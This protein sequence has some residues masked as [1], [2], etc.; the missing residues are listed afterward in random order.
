[1]ITVPLAF[2]GCRCRLYLVGYTAVLM[3]S[4]FPRTMLLGIEQRCRCL[5]WFPEKSEFSLRFTMLGFAAAVLEI[6]TGTSGLIAACYCLLIK[7]E[8]AQLGPRP[9]CQSTCPG[10]YCRLRTRWEIV[11]TQYLVLAVFRLGAVGGRVRSSPITPVPIRYLN[12]RILDCAI[13]TATNGFCHFC[14]PDLSSARSMLHAAWW[15]GRGCIGRFSEAE[16]LKAS[17]VAE[18]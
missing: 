4:P 8:L 3:E 5:R 6:P 9:E 7:V 1:V 15:T 11:K 16:E 18:R 14:L 13:L 17:A 12:P 2:K 10:R